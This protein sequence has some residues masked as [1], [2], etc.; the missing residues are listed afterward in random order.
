MFIVIKISNRITILFIRESD[1]PKTMRIHSFEHVECVEASLL[2][3]E[4]KNWLYI[5]SFLFECS[6]FEHLTPIQ[7]EVLRGSSISLNWDNFLVISGNGYH[8]E[9]E[10][11]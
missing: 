3:C 4:S 2:Q 7:Q 9:S 5:L 1:L 10:C 8:L 11:T 6:I